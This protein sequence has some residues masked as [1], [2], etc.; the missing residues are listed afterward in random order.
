MVNW[1]LVFY[2]LDDIS[3]VF[4]LRCRAT[5]CYDDGGRRYIKFDGC[6]FFGIRGRRSVA[7]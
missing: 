5:G 2:R 4:A 1:F 7:G 3:F 6:L